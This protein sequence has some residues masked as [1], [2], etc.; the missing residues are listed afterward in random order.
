MDTTLDRDLQIAVT[1]ARKAGE[2]LL[3]T[4][5][6]EVKVNS[7]IDKD[8]KLQA[9]EASERLIIDLLGDMSSYSILSEES[10]HVKNSDEADNYTWIVDP[11]DGSLNYLRNIDLNG[12]SI[13]LWKN[14][15][16]VMGVVFDFLHDRLY[17]G[18]VA[19]KEAFCNGA[20]IEVSGVM[21]KR[22][23]IVATGFP[24]YSSFDK[25]TLYNFVTDVQQ[26]KKVRLFGS[27]AISLVH[28]AKGSVEV[29]KEN[30]IAIWDV[31]AGLAI[32]L[33]AGG[34]VTYT[35]GKGPEYLNIYASNGQ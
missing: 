35:E 3:Q 31:A 18:I 29:Y 19:K 2:F 12:V 11:L 16:P 20:K 7:S 15:A 26:Y 27:A 13:G 1:V 25:E 22:D 24:V 4:R 6:S 14:N 33:A 21:Q 34:T 17:T 28:V 8:I 23:S 32:V 9:D 30:N 5:N 10:G